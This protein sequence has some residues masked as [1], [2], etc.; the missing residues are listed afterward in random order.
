M[1]I[2]KIFLSQ[3]Q[4][5]LP[6]PIRLGAIEIKTR[7]YVTVRVETDTGVCGDAVGY[8]RGTPL[9]EALSKVGRS[10]LG[11]DPLMRKQC[12]QNFE[13]ANITSLPVY[14]RALSLLDIA[15]W[16]IAAKVAG[17][18]LYQMLGGLRT[19]A[20]VTAVAGYYMHT[21]SIEDI[22][23]EV[24]LRIDQGYPRVKV[25]LHGEDQD[26]DVR[27]IQEVVRRAP[28]RVAADA[29]WTWKNMTEAMRFCRLIDDTGLAFLEDPFAPSAAYWTAKLQGK[30][31]TPIAAGEDVVDMRAMHQLASEVAILRVDAT[32][33]GG[34]TGAVNAINLA[35]LEGC[36]VFP[37]VFAPLH[38]HFACA[39]DH[40]E[41]VE[42]IP[43]ESGADPMEAFLLHPIAVNNG[44]MSPCHEPGAGLALDWEKVQ[45]KASRTTVIEPD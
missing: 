30:L 26:F 10:L 31:Q 42:Y 34:I 39:F 5:P 35:S 41:G 19:R 20:P 15:L 8:P 38:I 25:M 29:H 21:R 23:A 32:T 43:P 27:Y 3:L 13:R 12:V 40:V 11:C 17:L 16:D 22:S 44:W 6:Q 9:V 37:H 4:I 28:G 45:S 1:K 7:D 2:T 33:C 36:T 14:S 18:P 24:G